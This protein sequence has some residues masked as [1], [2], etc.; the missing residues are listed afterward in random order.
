[1]D[2]TILKLG[3]INKQNIKKVTQ[4]VYLFLQNANLIKVKDQGKDKN[5]NIQ[6]VV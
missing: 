1:M 5:K 3:S 2:L 4:S 6:L